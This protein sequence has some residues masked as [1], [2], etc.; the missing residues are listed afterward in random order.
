MPGEPDC[1]TRIVCPGHDFTDEV[2]DR[3]V[4]RLTHDEQGVGWATY[5]GPPTA[6]SFLDGIEMTDA[7]RLA[8]L[9][10]LYER[11]MTEERERLRD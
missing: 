8:E 2:G 1:G 9:V 7:E 11:R 4:Y 3:S 10:G 6:L 5:N